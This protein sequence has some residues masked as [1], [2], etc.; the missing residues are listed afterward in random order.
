MRLVFDGGPSGTVSLISAGLLVLLFVLCAQSGVDE[1]SQS[2]F[3][4]FEKAYHASAHCWV[5]H[6]LSDLRRMTFWNHQNATALSRDALLLVQV[7]SACYK[8]VKGKKPES[9][10]VGTTS[11]NLTHYFFLVRIFFTRILNPW[12]GETQEMKIIHVCLWYSK[13]VSLL[14]YSN[15]LNCLPSW[16]E[17]HVSKWHGNF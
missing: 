7:W 10:G 2:L 8:N 9:H 6:L 11:E 3:F 4:S 13:D 5:R 1:S 17:F 15:E 16:Y 12:W 14:G